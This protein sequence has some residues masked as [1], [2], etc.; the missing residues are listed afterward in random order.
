MKHLLFISIDNTFSRVVFFDGTT[1]CVTSSSNILAMPSSSAREIF[2]W[3]VI[4]FLSIFLALSLYLLNRQYARSNEQTRRSADRLRLI[5]TLLDL[6][7]TYRNSPTIFAEKFKDKVNIR[8]LKSY[9]VIESTNNR[10]RGLKEEERHLCDLIEAGFTSRELC[11]I[12]NLKKI[13]NLYTK[14]H[15]IQQKLEKISSEQAADE[16]KPLKVFETFCHKNN[17]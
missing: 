15:R 1:F 4:V 2:L 7:Y 8:E 16:E 9:G 13:S 3:T 12:F 5:R 17:K 6:Y 14:Y 11:S 10:F